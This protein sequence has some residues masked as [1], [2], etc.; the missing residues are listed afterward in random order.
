[1]IDSAEEQS[2]LTDIHPEHHMLSQ[3]FACEGA[4]REKLSSEDVR[5]S[6]TIKPHKYLL[7]LQV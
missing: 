7:Y 5:S 6:K 1:M 3:S 2:E 4:D